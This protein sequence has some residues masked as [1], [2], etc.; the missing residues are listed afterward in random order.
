M[1]GKNNVTSYT[2][3]SLPQSS[4]HILIQPLLFAQNSFL[5]KCQINL[6]HT[7]CGGTRLCIRSCLLR[8]L[9]ASQLVANAT[10]SD[11]V[12]HNRLDLIQRLVPPHYVCNGYILHDYFPLK[13]IGKYL[14]LYNKYKYCITSFVGIF[15]CI[16]PDC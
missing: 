6:L 12:S 11:T 9:T 16:N 3:C 4:V 8:E 5:L 7:Q 1:N 13:L 2:K 10:R 14:L 15:A